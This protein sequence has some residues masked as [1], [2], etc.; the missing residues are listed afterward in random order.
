MKITNQHRDKKLKKKK[1]QRECLRQLIGRAFGFWEWNE[2]AVTRWIGVAIKL[3]W[4]GGGGILGLWGRVRAR[5]REREMGF[6]VFEVNEIEIQCFWQK[7]KAKKKKK[8]EGRFGE[9]CGFR[10]SIAVVYPLAITKVKCCKKETLLWRSY[11]TLLKL[12][13]C[14]V[15]LYHRY[16]ICAKWCIYCGGF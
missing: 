6:W 5:E 11:K 7:W 9:R 16:S 4:F 2:V 13:Y 14:G 3:T 8:T 10:S 1:N 12:E 15:F